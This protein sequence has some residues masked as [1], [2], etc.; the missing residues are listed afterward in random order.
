MKRAC[1]VG[2]G[3][4]GP[5]HAEALAGI[6]DVDLYGICDIDKERADKGAAEYHCKVFYDLDDCLKDEE[7]DSIH[8]CTPHYL[9]YGMIEKCLVAGKQVVSEK[10]ITMKKE[11][12][13][14]LLREFAGKPVYP[15]MQNRTNK[16]VT[17]LKQIL[18]TD[19][20]LGKLISVKG[21]MTWHRD[22]SYYNSAAWR[23]TLAYEGGGVLINQSVHTLD[24]MIYLAGNV[25]SVNATMSNKSLQG[26]IEVEDTVD[27][28]MKFKN[29]A[30]GIFYATNAYGKT[31]KPQ[32]ELEFEHASFQYIN[33]ELYRDKQFVCRDDHKF[34]G[35]E[36][37]G[38]GHGRLLYDL[39][40]NQK[41]FTVEDIRNTMETM[42]AMY[43]S[44]EH[45][46]TINVR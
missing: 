19:T 44:A 27:A 16:C 3:A 6:P 20:E 22:E 5:V 39:Y 24:L 45:G 25:E 10:P 8:I 21:I 7:I 11:E 28:F 42:F 23:G 33:G 30:T 17:T 37:W 32:L 31:K 36:Y 38:S 12:F 15:V 46:T 9:H 1:I 13:S 18:D 4:I 40:A 35:K 26:V 41:A 14:A 2:Y 34:S 29:G 43:E